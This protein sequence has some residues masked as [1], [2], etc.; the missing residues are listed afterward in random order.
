MFLL[1]QESKRNWGEEREDDA[2]YTITL[3]RIN[4]NASPQN[5]VGFG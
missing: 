3:K 1:L 5:V 4:R 2:V